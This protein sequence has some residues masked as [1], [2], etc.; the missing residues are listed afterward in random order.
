M[1]L[2][3][4]S[5]GVVAVLHHVPN[6]PLL[7]DHVED[8]LITETFLKYLETKDAKW[9]L[10]FPMANSAVKA[11]DAVQQIAESQWNRPIKTFVVTGASKRGWTTWLSGVVDKRVVGIAPI[12]ID[13]LHFHPQMKKQKATWGKYSE[14]IDDYTRKGLLD[15][16]E[17]QPD[18]PL[19]K[20]VDPYTYKDQ[21]TMPKLIVNGTNDPYWVVDALN[22]Y[23]DDLKGDKHVHY[24]P[25]GNHGLQDG[26]DASGRDR[27]LAT[28]AVFSYLS[29]TGKTLP[30]LSWKFHR[31]DAGRE[32]T[33]E[34]AAPPKRAVLWTATSD[35]KDFRA[36][37]WK[38]TAMNGDGKAF[39]GKA[40]KPA[41]GHYAVHGAVEYVVNKAPV[42]LSTQIQWE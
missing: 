16:L 25:N 9:P 27:A 36:A 26:K 21:L 35:T 8:D 17:N 11:M 18:H 30:K 40:A 1:Q 2:A 4:L 14:Q 6:Q 29:A 39:V 19:F 22:T 23:W 28:I 15:I 42:V 13:T 41:T 5:G 38:P 32:L 31:N 20:W 34:C 12:V 24:V 7:G 33:V 10:L 3:R 37:R